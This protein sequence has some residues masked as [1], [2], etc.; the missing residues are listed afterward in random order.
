MPKIKITDEWLQVIRQGMT[1]EFGLHE[2]SITET[3]HRN[4]SVKIKLDDG[5][6]ATVQVG[7]NLERC[8]NY[9]YQNYVDECFISPRLIP[10]PTFIEFLV[11][12]VD[13]YEM[14]TK[15]ELLLKEQEAAKA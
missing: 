14:N 12:G 1:A 13:P 4:D 15:A 8:M 10:F 11:E 5:M 6:G 7:A 3:L 9:V 2:F